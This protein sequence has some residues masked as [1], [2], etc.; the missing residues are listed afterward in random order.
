MKGRIAL[1]SLMISLTGGAGAEAS[2]AIYVGK[3]LTRDGSVFLAGYG[4]EPSSHWLE[5][6]PLRQ[7]AP[8]STLT[9]GAI[10][11]SRY[12]GELMEIPQ[13]PTTFRYLTMN[14]SY[15]AGFPAPL[16][17]GGLNEQGVAARG[18]VVL[19]TDRAAGDDAQSAA[20]AAIQRPVQDRDG[21]GP[22]RPRGRGD[23]GRAD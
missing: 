16:T 21:T 13:V 20:R 22:K 6:V 18:C 17:N 2:Y 10:P 11:E 14:Y 15:F 4:D 8:G 1:T 19:L 5:I 12:P 9:V 3:N 23:R 7:H